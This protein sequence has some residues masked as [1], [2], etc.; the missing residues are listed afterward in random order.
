MRNLAKPG[1]PYYTSRCVHDS[2]C[3]VAGST[4]SEAPE[5][6]GTIRIKKVLT[7]LHR[8]IVPGDEVLHNRHV[9]EL[10]TPTSPFTDASKRPSFIGCKI[11][12]ATPAE[13]VCAIWVRINPDVKKIV[14]EHFKELFRGHRCILFCNPISRCDPPKQI[15]F[16]DLALPNPVCHS[17]DGT[18]M[19]IAFRHKVEV[20]WLDLWKWDR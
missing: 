3:T 18:Q 8:I 13:G 19:R 6:R 12:A 5:S 14:A 15:A 2:L 16:R 11:L 10:G 17:P 4:T 1:I 20:K 9:V 7:L